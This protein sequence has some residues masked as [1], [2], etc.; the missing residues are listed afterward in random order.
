M[1]LF[2]SKRRWTES[3]VVY[4][5]RRRCQNG[6]P[7]NARRRRHGNRCGHAVGARSSRPQRRALRRRVL[8]CSHGG[9]PVRASR[10]CPQRRAAP[11]TETMVAMREERGSLARNAVP[12]PQRKPWWQCGRGEVLSPAT[13]RHALQWL[14]SSARGVRRPRPMAVRPCPRRGSMRA[15]PIIEVVGGIDGAFYPRRAIRL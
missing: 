1:S 13:P 10:P 7:Y 6:E 3:G 9:E 12:R 4:G 15:L 2:F 14:S 8:R 11:A 5:K